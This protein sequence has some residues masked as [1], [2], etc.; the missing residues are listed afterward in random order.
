MKKFKE[1][2]NNKYGML[3]TVS[4]GLLIICLIIKL[5][6]GNWFEL[7]SENEKF[8]SFCSFVDNTQWLKMILACL[9]CLITGYPFLCILLNKEKLNLKESLIFIPLMICKSILGWYILY[10]SYILDVFIIILIPLIL[11]KFKNWKRVIIGNILIFIFQLMLIIIRNFS[12]GLNDFGTFI[13]QVIIQIDYFLMIFLFY[14]YNIK[15][16]RKE[17]N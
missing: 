10:I 3:I 17:D 13:P 6:G 11:N 14:L 4:W 8:I 9:I 12:G 1:F 2:Y 15:N 5:F 7:S 16:I